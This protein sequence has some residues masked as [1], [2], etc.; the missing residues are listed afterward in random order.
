MDW[1]EIDLTPEGNEWG[2][3]M[4]VVCGILKS[5]AGRRGIKREGAVRKSEF[6]CSVL[7]CMLLAC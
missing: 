5:L 1:S 4:G 7:V 2:G 6:S 3:S